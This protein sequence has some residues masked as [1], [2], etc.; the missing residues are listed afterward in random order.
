ME[1]LDKDLDNGQSTGHAERRRMAATRMAPAFSV[2]KI[3][4]ILL[5]RIS[6]NS[7]KAIDA[8]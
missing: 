2:G 1:G 4:S 5:Y 6:S 7:D 3:L 8:N